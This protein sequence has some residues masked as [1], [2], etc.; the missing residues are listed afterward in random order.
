MLR[1]IQ[2]HRPATG[3]RDGRDLPPALI[4]HGSAPHTSDVQ[5]CHG[6]GQV[7]AHQIEFRPIVTRGGV[8]GGLARRQGKDQPAMPSVDRVKA[9][10]VAKKITV[11][12]RVLAVKNKMR[13][14]DHETPPGVTDVSYAF[15][16]RL[17]ALAAVRRKH[18][19]M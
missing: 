13:S 1:L 7:I 11:G 5:L 6:L 19:G 15:A 14:I 18:P 2:T 17:F 4:A 8:E 12:L 16:G 9:K 10:H 3:Q